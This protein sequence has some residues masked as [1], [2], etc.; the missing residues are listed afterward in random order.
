MFGADIFNIDV[1]SYGQALEIGTG[2]SD[3]EPLR[4]R[5]ATHELGASVKCIP[6]QLAN[7]ILRIT[8]SVSMN[9]GSV[10]LYRHSTPHKGW[11]EATTAV[12]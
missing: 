12:V 9:G 4:M 6:S 3:M 2:G 7:S 5:E 10:Y 11:H 8:T 1:V